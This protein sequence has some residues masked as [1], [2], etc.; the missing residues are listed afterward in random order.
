ATYFAHRLMSQKHGRNN[1]L[2]AWPGGLEW[3]PNIR[4]EDYRAYGLL[5]TLGR[6]EATATVQDMPGFVH[7]VTLNSM[8]YDRGGKVVGMI[9]ERLGEA[10]FLDFM[11][12]VYACYRF[13][14]LRV[15]DFRR[16]LEAYTGRSWEEFFQNWLYGKGMCDWCVEK[17]EFDPG[18]AA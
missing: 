13:R 18:P 12:R 10:A 3:M 15:A 14:I 7:L 1:R 2:L 4:R 11:R 17:V 16:E 6:G 9:E 8:A 5:G